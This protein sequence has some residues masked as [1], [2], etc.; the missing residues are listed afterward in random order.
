MTEP[1]DGGVDARAALFSSLERSPGRN[2]HNIVF[3]ARKP[4]VC[5]PVGRPRQHS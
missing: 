3:I 4:Q 5:E 2:E 1:C